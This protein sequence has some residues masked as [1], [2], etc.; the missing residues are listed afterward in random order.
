MGIGFGCVRA[1]KFHRDSA[2]FF[3]QNQIH[4]PIAFLV[5]P[6][7]STMVQFF[8]SLKLGFPCINMNSWSG[9]SGN[10]WCCNL[11]GIP[12]KKSDQ[13]NGRRAKERG[14]YCNGPHF[15]DHGL[16]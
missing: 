13:N 9:K 7:P 15:L 11:C 2:L 8:F 6:G 4:H 3:P 16:R 12:L 1:A 5:R 14:D 10:S